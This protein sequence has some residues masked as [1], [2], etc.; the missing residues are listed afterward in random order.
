MVQSW[1]DGNVGNV[2]TTA[3]PPIPAS[4]KVASWAA[5]DHLLMWVHTG[6]AYVR[7]PGADLHRVEAGTGIWLP[8][9]PDHRMWTDPGSVALPISVPAEAVR[10]PPTDVTHFTVGGNRSEWLIAQYAQAASTGSLSAS[11]DLINVL[12]R[13]N[14][15]IVLGS[16]PGEPGRYPPVPRSG[17]SRSVAR[18]LMHNPALSH[19]VEEWASLV[20]YS[21][22]TLR[23]Q[24]WRQTGMTFSQWRLQCRMAAASELLVAGHDVSHVAARTGFASRSGLTRAFREHYHMTPRDF[25]VRE[26]LPTP[27]G[28]HLRAHQS[29]RPWPAGDLVG[30][31][32]SLHGQAQ[33]ENNR[34]TWVF[35][36]GGTATARGAAPAARTGDVL[37]QPA[38]ASSEPRLPKGSIAV[39]LSTLCT[40]CIQ[41]PG[42]LRTH[43]SPA[44]EA[45]LL[46][47]SVSTHTL[48]Q[49]ESRAQYSRLARPQHQHVLDAFEE[50]L[51]ADRTMDV[52][53]PKDARA[54]RVA[55]SFLEGIGT[56]GDTASTDIPPAV[57][58]AFR[59]ET[60][61][62]YRRWQQASRM[63]IA[64][65]LLTE[66]SKVSSVACR[67]GYSQLSNFSRTFSEFHGISPREYQEI[68]LGVTGVGAP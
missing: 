57:H 24:F 47:C 62:T 27:A 38:G 5:R 65:E 58:Q 26:R 12:A 30:E 67:V 55:L 51:E 25:A 40:E 6:S 42:P 46:Y 45:Y 9:G 48:L 2:L 17:G 11:G 39:P 49:P 66:G 61:M 52:P 41:L 20:A 14:P 43:F 34:M 31:R 59:L 18:Q 22:S 10:S 7:L 33:S 3:P 37:W 21:P 13:N 50:Q 8:P 63:K 4:V 1:R 19:T 23:R 53:F 44:W 32:R 56:G 60:G 15:A 68:E 35:R 64:R 28:P 16:G 29:A 36:S 54:R